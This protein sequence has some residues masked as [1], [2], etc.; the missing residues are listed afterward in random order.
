MTDEKKWGALQGRAMAEVSDFI[1]RGVSP[2]L[3]DIT[4]SIIYAS[5]WDQVKIRIQ[6][7]IQDIA[8]VYPDE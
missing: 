3:S 6:M 8:G 7:P 1:V 5:V 4:C 2:R